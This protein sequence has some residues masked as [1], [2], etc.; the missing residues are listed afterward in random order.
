MLRFLLLLSG[1]LSLPLPLALALALCLI[2]LS[3]C[4]LLALL[5]KLL[6][7]VDVVFGVGGRCQVKRALLFKRKAESVLLLELELRE[8]LLTDYAALVLELTCC[9][10]RRG[11]GCLRTHLAKQAGA[12]R[13]GVH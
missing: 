3:L 1:C 4:I 7:R 5:E 2:L 12:F 11:R 6:G 10:R 9:V 13:H 8:P